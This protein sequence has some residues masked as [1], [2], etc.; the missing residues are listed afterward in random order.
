MWDSSGSGD[1]QHLMRVRS[2][3]TWMRFGVTVGVTKNV[4]ASE[5]FA[6]RDPKRPELPRLYEAKFLGCVLNQ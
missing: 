4:E 6:D 3:S 2:A 1:V 5:I